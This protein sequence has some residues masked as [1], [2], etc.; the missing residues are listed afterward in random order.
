MFMNFCD[1]FYK[2]MNV[3]KKVYFLSI[4]K[5]Y[6]WQGG[7]KCK[8]SLMCF[9]IDF[10]RENVKLFVI[11]SLRVVVFF[12]NVYLQLDYMSIRKCYYMF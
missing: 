9:Q 7:I 3:F 8:K 1:Y 11:L 5:L 12:M 6:L 10:F 2:I 4:M